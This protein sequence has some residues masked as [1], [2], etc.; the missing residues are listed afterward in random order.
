MRVVKRSQNAANSREFLRRAAIQVAPSRFILPYRCAPAPVGFG[1][2]LAAL[3]N[4]V[5][6]E[7]GNRFEVSDT[8]L[9]N[10]I[11]DGCWQ[12]PRGPL[13]IVSRSQMGSVPL[14]T[15]PESRA[16]TVSLT[17]LR[18][19]PAA[20]FRVHQQVVVEVFPDLFPNL[21]RDGPRFHR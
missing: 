12:W 10:A 18:I 20:L 2:G 3:P 15:S 19:A 17:M 7:I 14:P 16:L 6:R 5:A 4:Q 8:R 13:G 21:V 11:G 9:G 1:E